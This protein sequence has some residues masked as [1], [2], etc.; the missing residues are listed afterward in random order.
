MCD[1]GWTTEA[2]ASDHRSDPNNLRCDVMCCD[3]WE[4]MD[5]L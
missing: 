1:D 3:G 2:K 5:A 4:V